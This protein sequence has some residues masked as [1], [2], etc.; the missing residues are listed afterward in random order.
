MSKTTKII[1]LTLAATLGVGGGMIGGVKLAQNKESDIRTQTNQ[2]AEDNGFQAGFDAAEQQLSLQISEQIAQA[3]AEKNAQ[4]SSLQQQIE[5]LQAAAENSVDQ[6]TH[7][8]TL[9]ALQTAQAQIAALEAE[10]TAL[11]AELE[12]LEGGTSQSQTPTEDTRYGMFTEDDVLLMSFDKMIQVG[13]FNLSQQGEL[14]RG[15]NWVSNPFGKLVIPEGVVSIAEMT[16]NG[17]TSITSIVLPSTLVSIGNSAL[18]GVNMGKNI[19]LPDTL[20]SIGS[21]AIGSGGSSKVETIWIPESLADFDSTMLSTMLSRILTLDFVYCESEDA[22]ISD[23]VLNNHSFKVKKGYT[24]AEYLAEIQA[25]KDLVANM[26]HV[27]TY[28]K[29]QEIRSNIYV[30]QPTS[31]K[32]NTNRINQIISISFL[33]D[34]TV[35]FNVK[36][37]NANATPHA[38][39]TASNIPG[40]YMLD[41]NTVYITFEGA[42]TK[43]ITFDL[44]TY[45]LDVSELG[46]TDTSGSTAIDTITLS[47]DQPANA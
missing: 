17:A 16:F 45:T 37:N 19:I 10:V 13:F 26:Q 33:D 15:E 6:Q 24:K 44:T 7:N 30:S 2:E 34:N 21:A 47:I 43:V 35:E 18:T 32:Y 9:Q 40:Y 39:Y 41:G 42:N 22:D 5:T 20:E 14:S 46:F 12:A 11:E 4:I 29:L 38:L 36:S 8:A 31:F 28:N 23:G 27:D 1:G 25:R 3:L